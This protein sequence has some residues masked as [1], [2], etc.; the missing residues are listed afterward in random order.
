MFY[1]AIHFWRKTGIMPR[2]FSSLK[3]YGVTVG[4]KDLQKLG[5]RNQDIAVLAFSSIEC[6]QFAV[7][8]SAAKFKVGRVAQCRFFVAGTCNLMS[9]ECN[10]HAIEGVHRHIDMDIDID[11]SATIVQLMSVSHQ[12]KDLL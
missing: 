5:S 4:K 6:K 9:Y 2:F 7:R 11:S 1:A 12:Q 3:K 8:I 10:Q